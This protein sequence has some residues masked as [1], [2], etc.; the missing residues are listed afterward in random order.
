[1]N[2]ADD[3]SIESDLDDDLSEHEYTD[4]WV[5]S[6]TAGEEIIF[7]YTFASRE[8]LERENI[9]PWMIFFNTQ[10]NAIDV[11]TKRLQV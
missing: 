2:L 9:A 8:F 1:M 3:T 4:K 6:K 11:S 10:A 7:T 5:P